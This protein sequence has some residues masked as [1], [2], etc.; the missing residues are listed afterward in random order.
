MI[1]KA[2]AAETVA[3]AAAD[4]RTRVLR[5][6]GAQMVGRV[7]IALSRLVVAAIIARMFGAGTF[8]EYAL[9][10]GLLAIAEWIVDFGTT[11][12]FV[13]EACREP[14]RERALLR[15]VTAL[16]LVQVPI[17]FA[18]L[19]AV[20]LV[21]RYPGHVV[22]A[23]LVAGASL[24]FYAGVLV[25]RVIFKSHLRL[26]RE[27]AAEFVSVLAMIAMVVAIVRFGGGLAALMACHVVSRGIFLVM[28]IALGRRNFELSVKG[29]TAR[30]LKWG[31]GISVTIGV[32]G[33]LVAVY[34]MLDVLLLSKLGTAVELGYYSGAQ[35]LIW[36]I[37]L[38]LAAVGGTLY[39][40][41][42]R[43]WPADRAQFAGACQRG[44]DA[45][46]VLAG[47]ALSSTLAAAEFFLGLLGP[48]LAAGAPA[49]RLLSLLVFFK[50]ITSTL[51]P[52]LYV[53]HAQRHTLLFIAVAV[54]MKAVVIAALAS[55]FGYLGVAMGAL[56]VEFFFA[57]VPTVFLLRL[58]GGLHLHW[59]V[60]AKV[61]IAIAAA[62]GC[63]AYLLPGASI[64]AAVVAPVVYL[65]LCAATG[66]L[67][68]ADVRLLVRR[69]AP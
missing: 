57:V 38:A 33:L 67:R 14:A 40:V 55:R 61:A 20:I 17:A 34:E 60:A 31:A 35:R 6:T 23:G 13:R 49:L 29:V 58:H 64:A 69:G 43:H 51:G 12:V 8:G 27:V 10:L 22:H 11:E 2:P 25:Y 47:I 54:A 5:N 9:I 24:A 3:R 59:T 50:A 37:L 41:A 63:T 4:L 21:L 62:V 56:V 19:A 18:I 28:C 68:L 65:A 39:P 32:I 66:A 45:V 15:I 46:L 7:I 42:A 30:D 1:A 26:E 53:V 16:K 52:V 36:P 44:L 48:E